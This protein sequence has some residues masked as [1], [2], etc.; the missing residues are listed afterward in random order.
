MA[1]KVY[2]LMYCRTVF[3][4]AVYHTE[5]LIFTL[6]LLAI[7][8]KDVQCVVLQSWLDMGKL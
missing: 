5:T 2:A 3:I 4:K 1:R 8:S 7:G 6:E